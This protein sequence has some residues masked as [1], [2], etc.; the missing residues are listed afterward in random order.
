MKTMSETKGIRK[1]LNELRQSYNSQYNKARKDGDEKEIDKYKKAFDYISNILSSPSHTLQTGDS[2]KRF[3]RVLANNGENALDEWIKSLDTSGKGNIVPVV[4]GRDNVLYKTSIKSLSS[5]IQDSIQND[6]P[7]QN[8]EEEFQ[9]WSYADPSRLPS[10]LS[11]SV[12]E[13]LTAEKDAA[14]KKNADLENM[15]VKYIEDIEKLQSKIE[16]NEAEL[17]ELTDA[18]KELESNRDLLESQVKRAEE[19]IEQLNKEQAK[20][21]EENQSLQSAAVAAES[22]RDKY[23]NQKNELYSRLEEY[24]RSIAS[25]KQTLG[26]KEKEIQQLEQDRENLGKDY[27]DAMEQIDGL[28]GQIEEAREALQ[29]RNEELKRR[30]LLIE[31]QQA[32]LNDKE[33]YIEDAAQKIEKLSSRNERYERE[34]E[35]NAERIA[36][37]K[38]NE[39]NLHT[40]LKQGQDWLRGVVAPKIADEMTKMGE[41]LNVLRIENQNLKENPVTFYKPNQQ[42]LMQNL[43][44]EGAYKYKED[45]LKA[46][47]KNNK[48]YKG[49]FTDDKTRDQFVR[50]FYPYA[51][52]KLLMNKNKLAKQA[53]VI[54]S[55]PVLYDNL[56]NEGR[57]IIEDALSDKIRSDQMDKKKHWITPKK[58]T[59]WERAME[60]HDINP[61]LSRNGW[62]M[63]NHHSLVKYY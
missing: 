26:E 47:L 48:K 30:R 57:A 12:V 6:K 42:E 3:S 55:N 7:L 31:Q 19:Y 5:F 14:I 8:I 1:I 4:K 11:S 34:I 22:E 51:E 54:G 10:P 17:K 52:M 60:E 53:R 62:S 32:E 33:A 59:K 41:E 37:L 24:R 28:T 44:Y 46:V 23:I 43:F 29:R 49:L 39:K 16:T 36:A 61:N 18:R 38:D 20:L 9:A 25:I 45:E 2:I 50:D 35:E 63:S 27:N 58:N 15:Q 40:L 21:K 13:D 56:S